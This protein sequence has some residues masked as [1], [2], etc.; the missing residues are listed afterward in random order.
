MINAARQKL[1]GFRNDPFVATLV[2][3]G[4][5][6][7]GAVMSMAVRQYPDQSGAALISIGNTSAPG[8][9]GIRFISAEDDVDGIPE[10]S[11]EIVITKAHMQALPAAS[12]PLAE[13]GDPLEFYYDFQV[14]PASDPETPW[15][16]N[17][18]QTWLYGPFIVNGSANA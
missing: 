11:I 18:E 14:T 3:T 10:S 4:I 8:D 6:L 7:T 2:I 12:P 5:D 17:V 15:T 16:D 1:T 13:A 9:E